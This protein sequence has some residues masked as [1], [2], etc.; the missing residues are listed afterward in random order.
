L[1]EATSLTGIWHGLYSYPEYLE[2]V[3]FVATLISHAAHFSG[4]THEAIAGR[5]GAPLQVFAEVNGTVD[6]QHVSF[7]KR[8]DGSSGWSHSLMYEGILMDEHNEIEGH[9]IFSNAWSGR[10]MMIRGP[11]VGESVVRKVYEVI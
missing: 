10:F 7:K 6:G 8:Y 3:F 5:K 9:W 1:S 4:S 2:P 11:G